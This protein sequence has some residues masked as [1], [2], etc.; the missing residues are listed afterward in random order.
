MSTSE[1]IPT[2]EVLETGRPYTVETSISLEHVSLLDSGLTRKEQ[3]RICCKPTFQTRRLKNKGAILL[4][5]WNF[6]L[7]SAMFIDEQLFQ[8]ELRYDLQLVVLGLTLPFAGWLADVYFGRYKVIRFSMWIFWIGTILA[9]ASSVVVQLVD[10]YNH[11]NYYVFQILMTIA[12]IGLGGFQ[13][14][15]IQFGIDQL[16]DASTNEIISFIV[17]YVWTCYVS[18]FVVEMAFQCLPE[19][20]SIAT[21]LMMSVYASVALC[22]LFIFNHLLIKEPV[23][24]NPF[25]LVYNV[26]KY[27]FKN[28]H[29]RCRSAFTY[30]EDELPSRIDFGKNKY[31][32]PFTTEQVEDVKTFLRFVFLIAIFSITFSVRFATDSLSTNLLRMLSLTNNNFAKLSEEMSSYSTYCY[33]K[34]AFLYTFRY[35]WAIGFPFYELIIYPVFNR[36][37]LM[38]KSQRKLTLAGI[39]FVAAEIVALMLIEIVARSNYIQNNDGNTTLLHCAKFGSLYTSISYRWMGIAYIFRS[40]SIAAF[41]IGGLEFLASQAPYSMRGLIAGTAYGLIVLFAVFYIAISIPFR[42]NLEMWSTGIISCGFWHALLLVTIEVVAGICLTVFWKKY[43]WRKREDVLP[44]EH[45]FAERYYDKE[46]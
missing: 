10:S 27:A 31:G 23:T 11:I 42:R 8:F 21:M 44:N 7:F 24:Q 41:A 38:I 13:A 12:T 14:N 43:T 5:V 46:N 3:L 29:P 18:A 4:L 16:H 45:I 39:L 37:L 15:I 33:T 22:S 26:V 9:T 28:K 40:L 25:K 19:E 1:I 35:S 30:C 17:W 20:Y 32:G 2:T 36:F 34:E 6:L